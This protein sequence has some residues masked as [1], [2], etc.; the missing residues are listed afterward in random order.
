[1]PHRLIVT[2]FTEEKLVGASIE[3]IT[4]ATIGPFASVSARCLI[5]S[6]SAWKAFHFF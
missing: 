6:G 3:L 1:M 5:Q 4:L 2:H